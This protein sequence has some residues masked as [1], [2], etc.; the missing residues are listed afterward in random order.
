MFVDDSRATP[1]E[2][3]PEVDASML[4]K[5][6]DISQS[7]P[8]QADSQPGEHMLAA[9][10]DPS[11]DRRED[12]QKRNLGFAVKGIEGGDGDATLDVEMIEVEDEDDIDDIDDM[13]ASITANRKGK[14]RTRTMVRM[15]RW[16][17]TLLI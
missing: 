8:G 4:E 5:G 10:Y 2:G 12:E 7:T 6:Q 15:K 17:F 13:F 16:T 11:Q 1:I 9:D 3:S 14:E